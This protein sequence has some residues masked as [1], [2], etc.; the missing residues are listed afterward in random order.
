M[1][2]WIRSETYS[3]ETETTLRRFSSWAVGELILRRQPIRRSGAGW[4][5]IPRCPRVSWRPMAG[6]AGPA[7]KEIPEIRV[8]L[9]LTRNEPLPLPSAGP[10]GRPRAIRETSRAAA[11]K[12]QRWPCHS[13][14]PRP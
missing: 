14:L 5:P 12:I 8:S 4:R 10:A 11:G 7:S 9:R 3:P 6:R 1:Q 13:R 2:S